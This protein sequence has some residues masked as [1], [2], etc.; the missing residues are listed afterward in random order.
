M[1]CRALGKQPALECWYPIAGWNHKGVS[2]WDANVSIR[3]RHIAPDE[4]R[5]FKRLLAV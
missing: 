1:E 2:L 5:H 3:V 4:P